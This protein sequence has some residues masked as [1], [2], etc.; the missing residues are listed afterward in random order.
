[1]I[2]VYKQR[3]SKLPPIFENYFQTNS[4]ITYRK[5]STRQNNNLHC[6]RYKSDRGQS[7]LKFSGARLWN[8]LPKTLK[9]SKS[10]N[11]FKKQCKVYLQGGS[12]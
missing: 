5:V 12:K 1:M 2:F 3:H 10:V 7:T 11:I 8:A 6:P 4:Q 9:A